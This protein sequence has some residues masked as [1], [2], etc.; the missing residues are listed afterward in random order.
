MSN[1][2]RCLADI[3][4]IMFVEELSPMRGGVSWTGKAF[5]YFVHTIDRTLVSMASHSHHSL[6]HPLYACHRDAERIMCVC[7]C[8]NE[9]CDGD[10]DDGGAHIDFH[11]SIHFQTSQKVFILVLNPLTALPSFLR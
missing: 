11:F 8:G 1:D 2:W 4:A 7:M 5:H 10:D 3:G 9:E 6:T